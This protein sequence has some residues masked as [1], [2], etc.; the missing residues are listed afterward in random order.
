ML[1]P[2]VALALAAAP[3]ILLPPWPLAPDGELVALRGGGSLEAEGAALE[4]AGPGL[5]RVVP[6]P[7]AGRVTLRAGD[8]RATAAVEAASGTVEVLVRPPAPVKGRDARVEIEMVVRR[9]GGEEDAD[10][11]APVV[12]V[13]AGAIRDLAPS[14][15]GRFRAVYEPAPARHPELAVLLAL[16]PRCP[17][18]ATP[19]A[20]GHAVVP[21]A[22]AI[23]LP[24]ESEPGTRTTVIVAG[25]SFGPATADVRGRF[26][27]PIVVPPGA[28]FASAVSVDALGNR[29]TTSIDL[30]LP[31]VDRL[32][33][34]AWPLAIPADGRS[35]AR[36]WC[37]ASTPAGAPADGARLAISAASG[38]VGPL[39]PARGALQRATYR[40]P[41]GGGGREVALRASYPDGGPASND[42]VR[43][44]L[45]TAAPAEI[46][47]SVAREP[48]P[49]GAAAAA[50]ATVRDGRGDVIGRPAG[51]AGATEGFVAPDRFVAARAGRTQAAPLAFAL[52]PGR[53][54]AIVTLRREGT[55]WLAE[56]RT[57]DGRPAAGVRLRFGSGAEVA[58]DAR[59]EARAR[60]PE[61]AETV[62]AP[63]GARA[64]GWAG[65]EPPRAPFEIA[66]TVEIP[67]RPAS[68]VDVL[69]RVEGGALRWTIE[70]GEG[71][72]IPGRRAALRA[73]GVVLGPA[74]AD[75]PGGRARIESG[76]GPVAVIDVE[77][78]VAAVVE[79]P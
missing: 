77:T 28:R 49:F 27:V 23:D 60:G 47:A 58:T 42:E 51:P 29:K 71:R 74:V 3:E 41:S 13:S 54:A 72:A 2:V 48:V 68:A 57:V 20:I 53:E 73:Q 75:G 10:A 16:V 11:P 18:C 8:A 46:D 15:P 44:A 25:R 38:E 9:P 55:S 78:G 66:R 24:G 50:Q 26:K 62:V 33:C 6:A 1:S 30:R 63:G 12:K 56:A 4:P 17:L 67:L 7:G 21:L 79:V 37:V 43:I 35:E 19:R 52:A 65:I 64:A 22:A 40:A 39:A 70:D 59:G 32:A 69:A 76:R 36:V 61:A 45:A 5:F 14:G 34:A 31:E